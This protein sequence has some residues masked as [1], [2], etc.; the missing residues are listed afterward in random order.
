MKLEKQISMIISVGIQGQGVSVFCG[1]QGV[2]AAV[3]QRTN[4]S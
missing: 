3:T 2:S 1:I 4:K